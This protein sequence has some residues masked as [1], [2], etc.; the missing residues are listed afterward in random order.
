MEVTVPVAPIE[1]SVYPDECDVFGHLNQASLLTLFERARWEAL[2]AGPGADAFQK[3][4]V[5][6][7]LRKATVEYLRQVFPGE[8]LRFD[9]VLTDHGH[10]S[11]AL[12]QTARK[13]KD[14]E[15]AATA[16][17]VFVCVGREGK[18]VPVPPEVSGFLGARPTRRSGPTQQVTV[19][20]VSL[21]VDA[22]G[23]GSPVLFV[24]GFPLDRTIWRPVM[25]TLTGWRRIAPDLRGMGLSDA[26][27]TGYAMAEY[28]DDLVALLDAL[29]V[30]RAIVCGL[31]MGGYVA[32]ELM[33]RHPSRVQ[34]LVLMSTRAGADDVEGRARRDAM[35]ARVRR[36]GT[37]FL[38]DEMV[39]KL[40]AAA[41][42]ETMP[43]VVRQVSTMV[44]AS[45]AD[46]IV[47]ALAAMRDRSDARDL[48]PRIAVPTLVVAG[49]DDQLIPLGESRAMATAIPQAHF[50]VIPSAGHLAP[51]EQSVNT[52]RVIREFLESLL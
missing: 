12:R 5:W 27:E 44:T 30:E 41:S 9:L 39:P 28:A 31:S 10:T 16:D 1:L 25:S 48:L 47:G 43:D 36:D 20:G 46:G 11:F 2:A 22:G 19:R 23:E 40:L 35:A 45:P 50:A 42:I 15:L 13:T 18:P 52:S 49:S 4:G 7:A 24:H 3:H 37:G 51:L 6:P 33:R 34:G 21:A 8:R 29:H 14:G 17:F 32:F 38:A 26:P